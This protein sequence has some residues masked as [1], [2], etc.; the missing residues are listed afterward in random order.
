MLKFFYANR[1]KRELA[2]V[3]GV[4]GEGRGGGGGGREARKSERRKGILGRV[5]LSSFNFSP[6]LSPSPSSITPAKRAEKEP[7]Y[8]AV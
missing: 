7:A 5:P 2:C 3:A 1:R 6:S 8:P 4:I